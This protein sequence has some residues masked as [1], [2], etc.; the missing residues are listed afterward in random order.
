MFHD[1]LSGVPLMILVLLKSIST[2]CQIGMQVLKLAHLLVI[3]TKAPLHEAILVCIQEA[4][5]GTLPPHVH[6]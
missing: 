6:M 4:P 1:Y 5:H 2:T 3:F